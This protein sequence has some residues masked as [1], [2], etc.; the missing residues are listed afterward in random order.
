[1]SSILGISESDIK[2]DDPL[3]S[4]AIGQVDEK[5]NPKAMNFSDFE[6]KLRNDPRWETSTNGAN[7]LMD[8]ATRMTKSWG[9]VN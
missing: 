9:F 2:L 6:T 8:M 3:L 5:G 4:Q 7:T 1:M